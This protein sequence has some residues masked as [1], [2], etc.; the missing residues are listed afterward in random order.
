MMMMMKAAAAVGVTSR[1]RLQLGRVVHTLLLLLL[2]V[3]ALWV[4]TP[5]GA[6]VIMMTVMGVDPQATA[7]CG[8]PAAGALAPPAIAHWLVSAC[9]VQG[10]ARQVQARQVQA[11]LALL[12]LLLV[13]LET[14]FQQQRQH[15]GQQQV[16][17]KQAAAA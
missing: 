1:L 16:Q 11:R 4:L 17:G 12:L 15:Y 14:S 2:V 7:T 8:L 3:V 10:P 5:L 13:A 9:V 6:A